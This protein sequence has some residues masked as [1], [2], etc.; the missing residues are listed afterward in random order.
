MFW[1]LDDHLGSTNVMIDSDGE[2]VE[3]TLYYPFGGHREGGT[4]QYTFT[5]KEFDTEIGLYYFEARYYNPQTFVF[6]QADSVIPNVYNPQALNRYS[7]CY[8]NPLKYTDPD[9]HNPAYYLPALFLVIGIGIGAKIGDTYGLIKG[10][11]IVLVR[12][13]ETEEPLT[14]TFYWDARG[15]I[16]KE[17]MRYELRGA[18]YGAT[19]TVGVAVMVGALS[20]GLSETT[21]AGFAIVATGGTA[22]ITYGVANITSSVLD[23]K[24]FIDSTVDAAGYA[25]GD[26][27]IGALSV[28]YPAEV[29]SMQQATRED[30]DMSEFGQ[31][32]LYLLNDIFKRSEEKKK[33]AT[34]SK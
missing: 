20:V 29:F 12:Y 18:A 21:A 8:N 19:A 2:L 34:E 1:Y 17:R 14:S 31:G 22:T 7:Y 5:G 33:A 10:I 30:Y 26:A 13:Y 28:I 4:E 9:G 6:T 3:R 15:D 24:N 27:T 25:L 23:G 16:K 32:Y 11:D